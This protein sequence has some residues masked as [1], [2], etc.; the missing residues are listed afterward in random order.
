[1]ATFSYHFHL[2]QGRRV[3]IDDQFSVYKYMEDTE[4]ALSLTPLD[5]MAAVGP[6]RDRHDVHRSCMAGQRVLG[7]P[8]FRVMP[9][10]QPDGPQQPLEPPQD[11]TPPQA[12]AAIAALLGGGRPSTAASSTALEGD[13]AVPVSPTTPA[14]PPS[15]DLEFIRAGFLDNPRLC[16]AIGKIAA[17]VVAAHGL[18]EAASESPPEPYRQESPNYND[19]DAFVNEEMATDKAAD[20]A[21]KKAEVDKEVARAAAEKDAAD[22]RQKAEDDEATAAD[23][24]KKQAAKANKMQDDGDAVAADRKREASV[25]R[26]QKKHA[27]AAREAREEEERKAQ[28]AR[29]IEAEEEAAAARDRQA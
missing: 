18:A 22:A 4:E 25:E 26:R 14:A 6:S 1:M 8:G 2:C 11:V 12:A 19:V 5:R 23:H 15:P 28:K 17:E 3:Q 9:L 16:V 27:A 29:K 21:R 10:P 7:G 24:R 20:E 13:T